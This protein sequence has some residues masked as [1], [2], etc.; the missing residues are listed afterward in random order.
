MPLG[1][2]RRLYSRFARQMSRPPPGCRGGRSQV[3]ASAIKFRCVCKSMSAQEV[4]LLCPNFALILFIAPLCTNFARILSV[5][6]EHPGRCRTRAAVVYDRFLRGPG[7]ESVRHRSGAT[8]SEVRACPIMISRY[9][10]RFP[11]RSVSG[12]NIARSPRFRAFILPPSR[13]QMGF[14]DGSRR[15]LLSRCE[16][17]K[18]NCTFKLPAGAEGRPSVLGEQFFDRLGLQHTHAQ[19]F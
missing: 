2:P 6:R 15:D 3:S 12:W 10:G 9:S 5:P 17:L 4:F 16:A 8:P 18:H 11:S 14:C 1:Q 13:F 7:A 19:F